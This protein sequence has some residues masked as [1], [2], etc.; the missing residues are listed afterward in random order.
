[1]DGYEV[2][3]ALRRDRRSRQLRL[4]AMTG[5]GQAADRADRVPGRLRRPHRQTRERR[6]DPARAVRR[7]TGASVNTFETPKTNGNGAKKAA[8]PKAGTTGR[9]R[10][11]SQAR[12]SPRCARFK[13]G[14]FTA[15]LRDDLTGVD[16]QIAETFN[17]LVEHGRSSIR[18]EARRRS[19]RRRQARVTP[20][21]RHAPRS[22]RRAAGPTTSRRSTSVIEDLTG[23]ANEIARVVS[24]VAKR[25]SRAD[26]WTSR[27]AATAA[28]R[29]VPAPRAHRQ[30]HGRAAVAVRLRGDARRAR[31]RRR[32][33]ARRA[34]AR[35]RRV[36]ACGRT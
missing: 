34:G 3:R 31:G 27:T 19:P 32:G 24:A 26:A 23:H 15:K 1:M 13:R 25:R 12:C 36:A 8:A 10:A 6:Q 21:K 7:P 4:I 5:Y 35:P 30:R 28:P 33:Q 18:D 20:R 14:D 22:A 11:G 17:E 9:N 16:G 2:A 29:R